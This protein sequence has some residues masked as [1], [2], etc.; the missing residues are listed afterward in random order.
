VASTDDTIT[1]RF[2]SA[3]VALPLDTRQELLP[4]LGTDDEIGGSIR[5]AFAE[6]GATEPVEL[7]DVQKAYLLRALEHRT[8]GGADGLPEGFLALRNALIDDLGESRRA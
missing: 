4:I 1:L 5:G 3:E 6:A 7:D 2:R 8:I